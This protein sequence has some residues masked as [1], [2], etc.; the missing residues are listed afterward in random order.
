MENQRVA[1]YARVS[2]EEQRDN[3]TIQSQIETAKSWVKLQEMI[4]KP[5]VV[6]DLYL[7]DGVSGTIP[8]VDRPS[9]KQLF[10][11][12][13]DGKFKLVLVYKIDRLGRDARD[14]LNTAHQLDQL[15][16]AVKSLSEEF[17]MSTPSGKFMFNIFAASAGFARDSQI[18]RSV[19]ATNHW[20]KEG[21][22]L[23]GIVPYGYHVV[24]KKK[25]ARLAISEAPLPGLA[26]SES[27]V[28]RMMYRLLAEE[29]KSCVHIAEHLNALGVPPHY[30]KDNRQVLQKDPHGKR[31]QHTAGIWRPSRIRNLIVNPVYKGE[32]LYGRRSNKM[33]HVISRSVPAIVDQET[34]E[35]AQMTLKKNMI[36]AVRNAKR[37]H[38][39]RGLI[40]CG[41]CGL[42][43]S[44]S[45]HQRP[46]GKV[47]SYYRCNGKAPFRGRI[48]GLCPSALVQA[49]TIEETIWNDVLSFLY[50]PGPVLDQLADKLN[51]EQV[52]TRDLEHERQTQVAALARKKE[53]KD[54][55][56]SLYRRELIN[57]DDLERQLNQIAKEE[58]Q[59]R[60][61]LDSLESA[62]HDQETTAIRLSQA[63]GLL[64]TLKQ[65]LKEEFT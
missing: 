65:R 4:D 21:V 9:G 64:H 54:R 30:T 63:Q 32:H 11:D 62:V 41:I 7:D 61:S 13:V 47:N 55:I 53:E 42:N 17:D 39:L 35:Q 24:G 31:K 36:D 38:L 46:N 49:E 14:I 28:V 33:R 50:D 8:F 48:H 52:Q 44:G 6:H 40:K 27:D 19:E 18:E 20:A 45:H 29:G 58:G 5:L 22:W 57:A 23:G 2:S 16:V 56:L 34:W 3:Q 1:I 37:K 26:M 10:D 25:Q 59:L 43:Y 12:A 15:G 60:A 51:Q